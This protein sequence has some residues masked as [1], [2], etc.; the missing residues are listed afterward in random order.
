ML[1]YLQDK[2]FDKINLFLFNPEYIEKQFLIKNKIESIAGYHYE[3]SEDEFFICLK[4]PTDFLNLYIS[5]FNLNNK[6]NLHEKIP[7]IDLIPNADDKKHTLYTYLKDD[8]L[9]H[10]LNI[11]YKLYNSNVFY[12][13]LK[14]ENVEDIKKINFKNILFGGN[15][16]Y[17]MRGGGKRLIKIG[18]QGGKYY[19][20]NG[21]KKYIK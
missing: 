18:P 20:N 9:Y 4:H 6:T 16:Y 2:N 12:L 7:N 19:I 3:L 15:K 11:L 1:K 14:H 17:K 8:D 21:K 10:S 13:K 5:K